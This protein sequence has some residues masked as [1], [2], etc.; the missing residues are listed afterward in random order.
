MIRV[1]QSAGQNPEN[2]INQN[3]AHDKMIKT[4]ENHIQ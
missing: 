4:V 2:S 3:E 1:K